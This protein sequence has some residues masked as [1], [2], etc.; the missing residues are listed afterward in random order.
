MLLKKT[1]YMKHL[2]KHIIIASIAL[3]ASCNSEQYEFLNG[4]WNCDSWIVESTAVNNCKNNVRFTFNSDRTYTSDIGG[5]SDQ[6]RFEILGGKLICY[7]EGKMDIGVK[8]NSLTKDT[9]NFTMNR[10]GRK[11]T[12]VLVKSNN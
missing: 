11:E 7:P 5:L 9:L 2:F 1:E 8:I 4:T 10:S 6:G 12:M 3:L